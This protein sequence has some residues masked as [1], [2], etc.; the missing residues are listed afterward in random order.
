MRAAAEITVVARAHISR[1]GA[2]LARRRAAC[3]ARKVKSR[4]AART[5]VVFVRL[6]QSRINDTI[7]TGTFWFDRTAPHNEAARVH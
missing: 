6:A 7:D 1:N 3:L 2:M 4:V 5:M